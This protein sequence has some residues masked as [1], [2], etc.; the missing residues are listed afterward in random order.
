MIGQRYGEKKKAVLDICH[1]Y[2]RLRGDTEDGVKPNLLKDRMRALESNRY[3]LAVVGEAKAGKSTFINALLGES[4]L[5]TDISQCS[6]AVVEIF[7][8][9]EKYVEVEYADGTTK[10]FED[11]PDTPDLDEAAEQLREIGAI[12][13]QY[14]AIPAT[15]IDVYILEGRITPGR[16]LP[17]ADLEADSNKP[18][19]NNEALIREYV[20]G[21]TPSDIPRKITFGFPLKYAFEGLRLVDTP[22]VNAVGGVQDVTYEYINEANA[23]LFVHSLDYPIESASLNDFVNNVLPNRKLETLF[24]VLTKSGLKSQGAI[25]QQ[26]GEAYRQ[27][28]KSFNHDRILHVDS[29]LKIVSE[30]I[31]QFDRAASLKEH[32]RERKSQELYQLKLILLNNVLED[33]GGDS[34][35]EVI[36]AALRQSSNFDEMERIIDDFSKQ[37]PELQLS[38][39]CESVK[40]GFDE[41]KRDLDE[42]ISALEKK[43]KYPQK[44][45]REIS[46]IQC[47]LAEYQSSLL[48]HA[49]NVRKQYTGRHASYI[50]SLDEITN[51]HLNDI[52]SASAFPRARKAIFDYHAEMT[53]FTD[54][55]A[56]AIRAKFENEMKRLGGEFKAAYDITVPTVDVWGIE[57][58]TKE[59]AFR[60]VEVERGPSGFWEKAWNLFTLG[61]A[62]FTDEEEKYE[63]IAHL[64]HFKTAIRSDVNEKKDE[65]VQ[66]VRYFIN[67]IAPD[68]G[69]ALKARIDARDKELEAIKTRK[70]ANEAIQ[71]KIVETKKR[72]EEI[73]EPQAR[74]SDL[75][76]NLP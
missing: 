71:E 68:F 6:S 29:M 30:E 39:I 58:E 63:E 54:E 76:A 34:D 69:S 46:K 28:G 10:R 61:F 15:L 37:A 20:Q 51:R 53:S 60:T 66:L 24:L 65:F 72:R 2:L 35:L 45:E 52:N 62:T 8:S 25:D 31:E 55:I 75:L 16:P 57:A 23:V 3:V 36:Q 7:K 12:R 59:A 22:G 49:D 4:V 17:I 1:R 27:Y 19:Q 14:R 44:F 50:E 74:V 11:D 26:V 33:V 67:R 18:L 43:W 21:R 41:Q 42:N 40:I 9:K 48:K 32:Y 56:A 5:P 64:K 73:T 47:L 70:E 38:E 13:D